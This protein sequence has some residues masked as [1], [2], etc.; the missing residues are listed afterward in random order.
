MRWRASAS[1]VMS[2]HSPTQNIGPLAGVGD[3][4]AGQS[5]LMGF[6]VTMGVQESSIHV[7][8]NA[9]PDDIDGGHVATSLSVA[10]QP[11]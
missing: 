9:K 4:A 11:W 1:T 2:G 8:L 10:I 6:A 5:W 3:E 7:R